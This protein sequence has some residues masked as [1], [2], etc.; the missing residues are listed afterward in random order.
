MLS[1][2]YIYKYNTRSMVGKHMSNEKPIGY[3]DPFDDCTHWLGK[4]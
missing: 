2:W 1:L 3:D 4:I